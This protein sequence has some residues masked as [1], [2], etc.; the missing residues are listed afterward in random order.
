M[1]IPMLGLDTDTEKF[2]YNASPLSSEKKLLCVGTS[3]DTWGHVKDTT[4][5]QV[6]G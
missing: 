1:I 3:L 4:E 6:G 5:T 2:P